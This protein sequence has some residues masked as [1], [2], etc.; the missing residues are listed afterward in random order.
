M[1]LPVLLDKRGMFICKFH[2]LHQ[3]FGFADPDIMMKIVHIYATS[4][5]GSPLWSYSSK[6]AEKLFT[7]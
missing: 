2:S 3:E 7:S 1:S 4:F 5:Y 6:E